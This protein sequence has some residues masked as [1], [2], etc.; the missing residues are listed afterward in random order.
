MP[1][2][3]GIFE[4]LATFGGGALS[5]K[6]FDLISEKMRAKAGQEEKKVVDETQISTA[7]L[8]INQSRFESVIQEL[9]EVKTKIESLEVKV[10]ELKIENLHLRHLLRIGPTSPIPSTR[11]QLEILQD[12]VLKEGL[13]F[14]EE[15]TPL[16]SYLK[17]DER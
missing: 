1:D 7:L 10:M 14:L 17:D 6:V 8:E 5:L 11:E 15:G 4:A 3:T 9:H 12:K 2:W 16:S 13:N